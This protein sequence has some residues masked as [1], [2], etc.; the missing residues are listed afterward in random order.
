MRAAWDIWDAYDCHQFEAWEWGRS[1]GVFLYRRAWLREMIRRVP[2]IMRP[3][4]SL[5]DS[6]LPA[7]VWIALF[8]HSEESGYATLCPILSGRG[9]DAQVILR[10]SL[11]CL[12]GSD[13]CGIVMAVQGDGDIL[14][15]QG[16]SVCGI[17]TSATPPVSCRITPQAFITEEAGKE[18]CRRILVFVGPS[19]LRHLECCWS[20]S[21]RSAPERPHQPPTSAPWRGPPVAPMRCLEIGAGSPFARRPTAAPTALSFFARTGIPERCTTTWVRGGRPDFPTRTAKET[22]EPLPRASRRA[23][24][25]RPDN[26]R[27]D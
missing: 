9:R 1:A 21:S 8:G 12:P 16:G 23:S 25:I 6:C 14:Q 13:R 18:S 26:G 7:G 24:P 19:P 17:Q 20:V 4:F 5:P 15:A 27:I 10:R 2:V 3:E 11:S 22:P